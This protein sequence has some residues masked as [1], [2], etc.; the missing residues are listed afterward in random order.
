[1]CDISNFLSLDAA[2]ASHT[3]RQP[4]PLPWYLRDQNK[5]MFVALG[6]ILILMV[7]AHV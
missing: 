1:M 2:R 4:R 3:Y 5:L 7:L 6:A